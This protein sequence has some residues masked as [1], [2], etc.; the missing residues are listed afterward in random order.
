MISFSGRLPNRKQ[1]TNDFPAFFKCIFLIS[2]FQGGLAG[3]LLLYSCVHIM[4]NVPA[5]MIFRKHF[6]RY[7][8]FAD[9]RKCRQALIPKSSSCARSAGRNFFRVFHFCK[10]ILVI[11]RD[12]KLK[13]CLLFHGITFKCPPSL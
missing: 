12:I 5:S 9:S 11:F 7:R 2:F 8:F 13:L 1:S 6:V 3:I 10:R 4:V